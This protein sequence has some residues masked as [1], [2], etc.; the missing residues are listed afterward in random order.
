MDGLTQDEVADRAGVG[1][2]VVAELVTNG[3]LT[4]NAQGGLSLA[5]VAPDFESA[6]GC[7]VTIEPAG[8]SAEVVR[9]ASSTDV[10]VFAR[11]RG[12]GTHAGDPPV[13]DGYPAVVEYTVRGS[14]PSAHDHEISGASHAPQHI[15]VWTKHGDT[16]Q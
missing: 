10:D 9:R 11:R 13:G 4:P 1:T 15:L 16:P 7:R 6:T 12:P 2:E 5:D 8:T 3:F 14:D